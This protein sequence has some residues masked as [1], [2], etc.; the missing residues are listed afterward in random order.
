MI[1]TKYRSPTSPI[2]PAAFAPA[3]VA[4]QTVCPSIPEVPWWFHQHDKI[5]DEVNTSLSGDWNKYIA[6][7]ERQR[8][9]MDELAV[10]G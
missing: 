5:I 9:A 4:A 3:S 8:A 2:R 10:E 7:W 6:R 1:L